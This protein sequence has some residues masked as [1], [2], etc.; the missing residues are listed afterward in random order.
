MFI[1]K[2]LFKTKS[3]SYLTGAI[4]SLVVASIVT[5]NINGLLFGTNTFLNVNHDAFD[6]TVYP[7]T[8]VP[9]WVE[10]T[11]DER[12]YDFA[13]HKSSDLMDPI[14]YNPSQLKESFETLDNNSKDNA[15]RN[16]KLTYTVPYMG[17]YK[18]DGKE[19]AGS[20]AAVD[21][22]LAMGTPIV[23][24][25]NGVVIKTDDQEYGFG[26][27]VVIRH[28]KVP[29]LDN[30]GKKVTY[31]SSY[32]HLDSFDVA[33]GD[34][35]KKG[36]QIGKSGNSGVSTTPHLH[37][38]IDKEGLAYYPYWPFSATEAR[39][40][41]LSFFE[42]V[43]EGLG[44][45]NGRK[46]T[47]HPLNYVQKYLDA[48]AEA[49]V[50]THE[51]EEVEVDE[52]EENVEEFKADSDEVVL[53]NEPEIEERV[54]AKVT[55]EAPSTMV[56]GQTYDVKV[57]YESTEATFASLDADEFSFTPSLNSRFVVP[58]SASFADGEVTVPFTPKEAGKL[59][60]KVK[61]GL[62]KA[63]LTDVDVIL[64]KDIEET[65]AD[66]DAISALKSMDIVSGYGDQTFRPDTKVSRVEALKFLV[67]SIDTDLPTASELR[68]KDIEPG[69]WY[70]D[71]LRKAVAA[72]S[73]DGDKENFDPQREINRAEFLKMLFVALKIDLDPTVSSDFENL[74]DTSAWY[75]KYMQAAIEMGIVT[76]D[77]A[78]RP[79]EALSRRDV[80][81]IVYRFVNLSQ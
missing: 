20:H 31:F 13:D 28:S 27:H 2:F 59:S 14:Y 24:I 21:I 37:F 17:S 79:D 25:A 43:N 29:S 34:V 74:F 72:G 35:V 32:S 12:D 16:A 67:E 48:K 44:A 57:K 33:P 38:Q 70:E 7:Y 39:N 56:L 40:E 8:A 62:E 75:G 22:K 4:V 66:F 65:D 23:S 63:Y 42:A 60:I 80:A 15:T 81:R 64:F 18:L 47:I 45:E 53:V 58:R 78:S 9:N 19:N 52:D 46:N 54:R 55:L 1:S 6:G 51:P 68:F 11:P 50:E 3:S 73:V 10:L 49:L 5:F 30:P 77:E 69:A 71:Y 61:A 36:Q 26:K 76:V 41:G